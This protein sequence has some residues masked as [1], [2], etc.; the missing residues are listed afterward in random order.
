MP[1]R[2]ASITLDTCCCQLGLT[3]QSHRPALPERTGGGV[4]DL[5]RKERLRSPLQ[6]GRRSAP[7]GDVTDAAQEEPRSLNEDS[8]RSASQ[9]QLGLRARGRFERIHVVLVARLSRFLARSDERGRPLVAPIMRL[10]QRIAK[11]FRPVSIGRSKGHSEPPPYSRPVA[12]E[13]VDPASAFEPEV[14]SGGSADARQLRFR[15]IAEAGIGIAGVVVALAIVGALVVAFGL[16]TAGEEGPE[17]AV[18]GQPASSGPI[19]SKLGITRT[20]GGLEITLLRVERLSLGGRVYL[21]AVNTGDAAAAIPD[22]EIT[23]RQRQEGAARAAPNRGNRLPRFGSSLPPDGRDSSVLFFPRM[24]KGGAVVTVPWFTR[25]TELLPEPVQ[26][27]F[28][29]K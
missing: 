27:S 11:A 2:R 14:T 22:T 21:R 26:F 29:V 28:Q 9:G 10:A 23:L 13:P 15:Q 25:S 5:R 16:R 18:G 3:R 12:A 19:V 4:T 7:D 17:L 6:R 8:A 24:R 20:V 1:S